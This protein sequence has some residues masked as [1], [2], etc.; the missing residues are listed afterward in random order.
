MPHEAEALE[1]DEAEV[2][3]ITEATEGE[4]EALRI[5]KAKVA[6]TGAPRTTEA[7]VAKA[8]APRT[9]KAKAVEAG[10]GAVEPMAQNAEM[11]A[12]QALVLPAV[13]DP[14]PSQESARE[15]EVHSISS[16][17]ISWGKEVVDAKAASTVEQ[18]ALTFEL[19][20]E[21]TWVAKASVVV[22]AVLKGVLHTGIKRALAIVSSHYA[23]I[24][25]EAVSDFY[26]MADDDEKAEEEV[27]KLVEAAE[28]PG[29]APAK[30]FEEEVV[31]PTLTIDTSNPKP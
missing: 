11:E 13:Q 9:T 20:K 15:V 18:P 25:L 21:V 16:D 1:S 3:S 8:G 6:D 26:V 17:D 14:L 12:G 2:P 10:L 19:E 22:Q 30:L 31:P 24:N 7:E 5:P 27:M 4:A 23:G 29:M 28:A